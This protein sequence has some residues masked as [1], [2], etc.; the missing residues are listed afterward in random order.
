MAPAERREYI[1]AELI[2]QLMN[3]GF[4]Q[5]TDDGPF[6]NPFKSDIRL[7]LSHSFVHFEKKQQSAASGESEWITWESY[8]LASEDE[9][10]FALKVID[11]P[12]KRFT[13]RR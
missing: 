8:S 12:D 11:Q 3:R 2:A 6:Y 10:N 1:R 4:L 7:R 9:A 13:S 5:D